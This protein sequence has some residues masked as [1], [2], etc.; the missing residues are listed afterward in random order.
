MKER[1]GLPV[2]MGEPADEYLGCDSPA[3]IQA[4]LRCP[5]QDCIWPSCEILKELKKKE[6]GWWRLFRNCGVTDEQMRE[7]YEAGMSQV[8][9]AR[10]FGLPRSVVR[11]WYARYKNAK[12]KRAEAEAGKGKT[13]DS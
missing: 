1:G 13:D 5:Y 6:K 9:I 2:G 3:Q 12:T 10:H 4:C 7:K 11:N 8:A